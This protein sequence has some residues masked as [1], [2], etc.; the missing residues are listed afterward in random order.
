MLDFSDSGCQWVAGAIWAS[1]TGQCANPMGTNA[2]TDRELA[3]LAE[4]TIGPGSGTDTYDLSNVVS[5]SKHT[6]MWHPLS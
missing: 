1:V 6:S 2:A 3:N 5:I 4:F